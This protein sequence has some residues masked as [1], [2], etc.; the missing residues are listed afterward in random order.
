MA[1][2]TPRRFPIPLT[3]GHNSKLDPRHVGDKG[4]VKTQGGEYRDGDPHL[5]HKLPGRSLYGTVGSAGAK[6]TGGALATFD[7]GTAFILAVAGTGLFYGDATTSTATMTESTVPIA[8][9]SDTTKMTAAHEQNRWFIVTGE[10]TNLVVESD[11]SVV[12]HG[13]RPPG[14][15][16]LTVT[17]GTGAQQ[18]IPVSLTTVTTTF[19]GDG[20]DWQNTNEPANTWVKTKGYANAYLESKDDFCEIEYAFD[21][22]T[23]YNPKYLDVYYRVANI[24]WSGTGEEGDLDIDESPGWECQLNISVS[25]NSGS[26]YTVRKTEQIF[27]AHD[28]IQHMQI[29]IDDAGVAPADVAVKLN[30]TL[31]IG[32]GRISLNIYTIRIQNGQGLTT[33]TN[34]DGALF[35]AITEYDGKRGW[36]SNISDVFQLDSGVAY[37]SA[38]VKMPVLANN[39]HATHYR[40]Y[41][42]TNENIPFSPDRLGKLAEVEVDT[43]TTFTDLFA[44][45]PP[46]VQLR[47]K[48][49]MLQLLQSGNVVPFEK[50]YPPPA[51]TFIG[52]FG[53]ALFGLN[54]RTYH[55]AFASEP[56]S[57]PRIFTIERMPFKEHSPLRA[58]YQV[59]E[60]LWIGAEAGIIL[61]DHP[62]ETRQGALSLPVPVR[63]EGAPGCVGE[64]AATPLSF[65]GEGLIAWVSLHGVMISNLATYE[66]V[67]DDIDWENELTEG[68]LDNAVLF[69]REKK[70]QL[71]LCYDSTGNGVNDSFALIHMAKELR[72]KTGNPLITWGHPGD[73]SHWWGGKVNGKWTEWTG[74]DSSSR[75]IFLEDDNLYSDASNSHDGSG[76]I[77]FDVQTGRLYFAK[78]VA[79]TKARVYHTAPS[80]TFTM[81]INYDTGNDADQVDRTSEILLGISGS[82]GRYNDFNIDAAGD[83]MQWRFRHTG[84][85]KFAL[86]AIEPFIDAQ[87]DPGDIA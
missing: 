30:L 48:Y 60:R 68:S 36:E 59:G 2:R 65:R 51:M 79:I 61:L 33:F 44:D 5:I 22:T 69:W 73:F 66:R 23:D 67:T 83:F 28:N 82:R 35:Y 70:Q 40:I 12:T 6:V 29:E 54:G 4:L 9:S 87:D 13:M 85:T 8:R 77:P 80:T 56:A 46:T 11:A 24:Q 16:R 39:P 7:D 75:G 34:S 74:Q 63:L 49:K 27:N 72:T 78:D 1:A 47:P 45:S 52:N 21:T 86:G 81:T 58:A 71:V 55:Q 43:L 62:I 64:Y 19:G 50:N 37:N 14:R 17:P 84:T 32:F 38:H 3:T 18:G 42:T 25:T 41:R 31:Q 57:W 20:T 26:S 53:G 15:G 76:N 10:N